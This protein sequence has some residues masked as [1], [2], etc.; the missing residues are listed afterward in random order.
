MKH[1][2]LV[3]LIVVAGCGNQSISSSANHNSSE[4]GQKHINTE[5]TETNTS[6]QSTN[7]YVDESP[8][9]GDEL[10]VIQLL[11]KSITYRNEKNTTEFIKLLTADSNVGQPNSRKANS[12][13]IEK[14]DHSNDS[15]IVVRANVTTNENGVSP[16]TYVFKK[17]NSIWKINDID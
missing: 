17:W 11:N 13:Q 6:K 3:V 14:I 12:V 16:E 15:Q 7:V 4:L 8:Y 2:L 1:I 10:E 9:S 5:S